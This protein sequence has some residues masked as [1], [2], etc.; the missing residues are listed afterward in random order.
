VLVAR[1]IP[2]IFITG[3]GAE[4][5]DRRFRHIPVIKKPVQRQVLQKLF[6]LSPRRGRQ[7]RETV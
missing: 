5:I 7:P 3:Y 1:N 4:S 6:I 2:F